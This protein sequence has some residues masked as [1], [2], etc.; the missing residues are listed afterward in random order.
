L[1][2]IDANIYFNNEAP[3][4]R[5]DNPTSFALK[6]AADVQFYDNKENVIATQ[7]I[8]KVIQP[9]IH[10]LDLKQVPDAKK[11]VIAQKLQWQSLNYKS[12]L[13]ESTT[14]FN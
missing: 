10:N 9:G 3:F 14:P 13:S 1:S 7:Q 5:I 8:N 6:I 4:L 2:G 12:T 11:L